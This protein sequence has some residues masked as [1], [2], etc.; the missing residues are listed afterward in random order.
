MLIPFA[1]LYLLY[2]IWLY[3]MV[4]NLHSK[5]SFL[6]NEE[7]IRNDKYPAFTR[8][9]YVNWNKVKFYFCGLFLLPIKAALMCTLIL[10]AFLLL[11]L[12]SM[13]FGIKDFSKPQNSCYLK[14][15]K[16]T[17]RL[18]CRLL[19]L[20]FG[21]FWLSKDQIKSNGNSY[22]KKMPESKHAIIISNHTSFVDI[23]YLLSQSRP[24]C[25]VSNHLVI[26]Y[27]LV[28]KIAQ[29][30]QCVF[31]DRK[32]KE[33]KIKCLN[34]LKERSENLRQCPDSNSF[35]YDIY[36]IRY[37]STQIYF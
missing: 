20:G 37:T 33:S 23:L 15:A 4:N 32:L 17:L 36:T 27:P 13:L 19:L 11:S 28:G 7:C 6:N 18:F 5:Y 2:A 1:C 26:K 29:I 16:L 8:D 25:F 3:Y 14:F 9:D 22:L 21:F 34:D 10:M 12:F 30:I 35:I 24:V 31:V